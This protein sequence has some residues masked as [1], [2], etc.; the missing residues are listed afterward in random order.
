M[1]SEVNTMTSTIIF[2]LAHIVHHQPLCC[3][4]FHLVDG[5]AVILLIKT[6]DLLVRELQPKLHTKADVSVLGTQRTLPSKSCV[7][8][9]G[10][11]IKPCFIDD[12]E[13]KLQSCN[14][15]IWVLQ[16]ESDNVQK[17]Q[18]SQEVVICYNTRST[19]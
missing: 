5:Q 13:L 8:S 3:V 15:V 1:L 17:S 14:Q 2:F 16:E 9:S 19:V 10:A 18:P 7:L 6:L 4:S 11:A 12:V